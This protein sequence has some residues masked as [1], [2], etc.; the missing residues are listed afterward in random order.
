MFCFTFLLEY[1]CLHW[2]FMC[3]YKTTW[4]PC[5]HVLATITLTNILENFLKI[6]KPLPLNSKTPHNLEVDTNGGLKNEVPLGRPSIFL[7]KSYKQ[8]VKLFGM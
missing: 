8:N 7:L 3:E 6:N 5:N 1:G 4:Y 2:V